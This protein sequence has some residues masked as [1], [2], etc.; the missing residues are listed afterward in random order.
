MALLADSNVWVDYL[1]SG[2]IP[3]ADFETKLVQ[4]EVVICGI[5]LAEVLSGIKNMKEAQTVKTQ[6]LALPYLSERRS[7]FIKAADI[8][9]KSQAWMNGFYSGMCP[10]SRFSRWSVLYHT[11]QYD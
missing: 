1:N 5:V 2:K 6:L 4:G 7:T 9:K 11:E 3:M 10:F 8:F